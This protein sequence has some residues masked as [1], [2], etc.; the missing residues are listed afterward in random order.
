M[1]GDPLVSIRCL[2]YNHEPFLR[3][4]LDG[5]V[6]QQTTF[7]FEAI[8]HDDA[9]T[10]G[11]AS[12]IREYAEKYP[13][14][15]KPI[16]ETE[17]Q[18]SKHDGSLN[19][20]MDAAIHPAVKYIAVCEGDDYWT[21]P[22]KL[23]LQVD[24]LESNPDYS[25]SVHEYKV[26]DE[27][28]QE[29]EPHQLE[30]LKGV[31]GNLALSLEDFATRVFFTKTLT[32]VYRRSALDN[33]KYDKYD[34]KFDWMLF[35]A[36]ITQGKCYL[37]NRVMGVYR[38][39]PSSVTASTNLQELYLKTREAMLSIAREEKTE[40]SKVFV[41]NYL[42]TF[43]FSV[44]YNGQWRMV[45]KYFKYLGLKRALLLTFVEP[46]KR[47]RELIDYKR[48]KRESAFKC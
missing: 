23:Q 7:P 46:I 30:V 21:D 6:M 33:S 4:C 25:F 28:K 2:V 5:F 39:Q 8:I 32:S 9:S 13:D 14:I 40:Q 29:Y 19:K 42:K 11:S 35:Y 34:S 37:F 16:Y 10:D 43:A 36:L 20:I 47:F 24:F 44:Y 31:K 41:F 22:Q 45:I 27:V 3:Q 12:I 15:I 1:Q 18:Y 26:W 17:N 48:G 38:V